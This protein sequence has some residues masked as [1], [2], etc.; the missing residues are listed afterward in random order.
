MND[1][2]SCSCGRL[3]D[4]LI[5]TDN[6]QGTKYANVAGNCCGEWM[7]EFRANY[8]DLNSEKCMQLAASAWNNAPRKNNE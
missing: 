2:K 3:P 7:I 4:S 6:G 1:I 5:I 8:N